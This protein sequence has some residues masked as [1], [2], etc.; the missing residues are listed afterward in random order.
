MSAQVPTPRLVRHS[1]T[2]GH[3]WDGGK[4]EKTFCYYYFAARR[5]SEVGEKRRVTIGGGVRRE[6]TGSR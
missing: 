3:P 6:H 1:I 4:L 5:L 2:Y